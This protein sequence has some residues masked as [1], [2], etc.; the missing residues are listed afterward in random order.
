MIKNTNTDSDLFFWIKGGQEKK[1][2]SIQSIHKTELR[3]TPKKTILKKPK[4]DIDSARAG[5]KTGWIRATFIVKE[6]NLKKIKALA[7]WNR[8]DIKQVIDEA[9]DIYLSG[10]SIKPLPDD[11]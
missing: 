6:D 3:S 10:Q 7:Y 11:R 8:K 9:L 4:A 5:L 2:K 1:P